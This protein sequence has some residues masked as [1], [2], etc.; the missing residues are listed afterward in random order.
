MR[1]AIQECELIK[2]LQHHDVRTRQLFSTTTVV[3]MGGVVVLLNGLPLALRSPLCDGL[4]E[5]RHELANR[6]LL[7]ERER[8]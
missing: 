2:R 4:C 3:H 7:V 6:A 1:S 5:E 8:R